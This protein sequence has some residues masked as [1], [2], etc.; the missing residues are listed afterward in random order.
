MWQFPSLFRKVLS[1]GRDVQ[2]RGRPNMRSVVLLPG[3]VL[4]V[5]L[6]GPIVNA[7]TCGGGGAPCESYGTASAVFAGTV[8]GER[9]SKQP[10]QG[11]RTEID[12]IPRAVKFS[13][14]QAYSGVTGT[15]V[16]VY[17]GRG[18]GDCGYGFQI[19][20]RYLVYAY[21]HEDRLT[22]SICTRTRL[23]S[24]ATEDLAFP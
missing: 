13:V 24:N 18:G 20:Q 11:D 15:E 17:T 21:R 19:G 6:A 7:C 9:V 5:L 12:W 22:T 23:F 2:L 10:K 3:I 4:V 16:E 8:I 14:E 1:T